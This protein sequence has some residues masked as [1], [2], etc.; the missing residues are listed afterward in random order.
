MGGDIDGAAAG[1][2]HVMAERHASA[3]P[4]RGP[5]YERALAELAELDLN[6]IRAAAARIADHIHRTPVISSASLD[7]CVGARVFAKAEALQRSG[8]FKARGAFN[9]LLMVDDDQRA[10]GVV[11]YSSGNHGAAVS[12][13]A[14]ELGIAAT[15]VVPDDVTSAKL[16]AIR[17]HGAELVRCDAADRARVAEELAHEQ[18]MSLVAPYDDYA[19]MAGQGTAALELL[20]QAGEVDVVVVPVS[21]GGL[22]AG[23]A[24]AVRSVCPD[25]R[26]IGVEPQA[27]DDTA[28]SMRAGTRVKLPTVP[29][30]IAD[31]LRARAPGLLT[32]PINRALVEQVMVVDDQ[33]IIE[34]MRFCRAALD[35]AVEPSGA[36]GVAALISGA[37][38]VRGLRVAV[39]LSG[40]NVDADRLEIV[41][42]DEVAGARSTERPQ[43]ATRR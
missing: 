21:G 36:V 7:A 8:S 28:Q 15:V 5:V 33:Q 26:I 43:A 4:R 13:A 35:L 18:G 27:A 38:D 31:G 25:A 11:A 1:P 20:E 29:R 30:T 3:A 17:A 6:A 9:R 40:G 42:G 19:V 41:A 14:A 12:L 37:L 16:E 32:F 39:L 24:V 10:R 23:T 2:P 34:A 22:L